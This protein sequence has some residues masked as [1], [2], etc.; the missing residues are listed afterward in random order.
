VWAAPTGIRE[1]QDGKISHGY[2]A[3][4][5]QPWLIEKEHA[6]WESMH[7]R[8]DRSAQ[9]VLRCRIGDPRPRLSPELLIKVGAFAHV[10]QRGIQQYY[11]SDKKDKT[12]LRSLHVQGVDEA[13]GLLSR[14]GRRGRVPWLAPRYHTYIRR[15]RSCCLQLTTCCTVCCIVSLLSG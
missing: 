10:R 8:V 6:I 9:I 11:S 3:A 12:I 14:L 1:V 15:H 5:P 13:K 7:A 2:T 4:I